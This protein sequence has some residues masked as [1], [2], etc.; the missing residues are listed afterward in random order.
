MN[1]KIRRGK[2][3]S[4][5]TTDNK[6]FAGRGSEKEAEKHQW[7]LDKGEMSDKFDE[8]IRKIFGIKCKYDAS[9]EYIE[10][11]SEFC[12]DMMREVNISAD[13]GDFK[14][15]ISEFILDLFGFIG[16]GKWQQIHDFLTE[17]R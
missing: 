17:K 1:S 9:K 12:D 13:G 5:T 10:E 8:F 2:A 3:I 4:Y 16:A 7:A 15:E 11:E 6:V 14:A